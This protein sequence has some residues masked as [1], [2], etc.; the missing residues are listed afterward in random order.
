MADTPLGIALILCE[1]IISSQR[2]GKVT[3]GDC[4]DNLNLKSFPAKTRIS[5]YVA[6]GGASGSFK[7]TVNVRSR[8]G[9]CQTLS[10]AVCDFPMVSHTHVL[11]QTKPVA[12]DDP[13]VYLIEVLCDDI[14][15]LSRYFGVGLDLTA[16]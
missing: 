5:Y 1:E 8:T 15:T 2:T 7:V 13:D 6:L 10:E 3:L 11:L 4:Y 9:A 16:D 14:P 12:F